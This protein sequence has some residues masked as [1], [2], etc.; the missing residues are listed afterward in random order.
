MSEWAELQKCAATAEWRN[1]ANIWRQHKKNDP[2]NWNWGHL[3]WSVTLVIKW[4]NWANIWSQH[5]KNDPINWNWGHSSWSVTLVINSVL[6][7]KAYNTIKMSNN[8]KRAFNRSVVSRSEFSREVES[9]DYSRSEFIWRSREISCW[10][11]C[12]SSYQWLSPVQGF[13]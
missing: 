9:A 7:R 12:R 11:Q 13:S 3:S 5:K 8:K 10:A 6:N 4:R 1:W 2:I